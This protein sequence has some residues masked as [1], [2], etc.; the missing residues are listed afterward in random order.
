MNAARMPGHHLGNL[1]KVYVAHHPFLA[2]SL[3]EKL[4]ELPVFQNGDTVFVR[5]GIDNDF[6]FH[7]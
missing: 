1:A 6:F 3:N 4:G 2:W 5:R 7:T